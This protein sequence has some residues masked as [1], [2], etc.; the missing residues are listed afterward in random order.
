MKKIFLYFI[1]IF[2]LVKCGLPDAERTRVL[3]PASHIGMHNYNDS[4]N[5]LCRYWEVTDAENPQFKDVANY[6][7]GIT[8]SPGLILFHD[9]NFVE[10]PRGGARYGKMIFANKKIEV[11]FLDGGES[12]YKILSLKNNKLDLSRSEDEKK[13]ILHLTGD[14]VNYIIARDNPFHP[15]YNLWRIKPLHKESDDEI[16]LRMRRCIE[17]YEKFFYDNLNRKG[18]EINFQGLPGCFIWYKG[19]I[20]V[21]KEKDL[22]KKFINCFYSQE[23]ALKARRILEDAMDKK[24][25][26]KPNVANWIEQTAPVLRQIHDSL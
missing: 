6:D 19:G 26:W 24:Y 20:S 1:L 15:D 2:T 25:Y 7:S 3:M 12:V 13:T 11:H 16:K 21:E 17:F 14:S 23:Q 4:F 9:S 8:N 22:D 10:N 18:K 5:F